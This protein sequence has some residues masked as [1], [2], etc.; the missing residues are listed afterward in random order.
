V[1]STE[2]L[3]FYGIHPR[4]GIEALEAFGIVPRC[5]NWLMHDYLAPYWTY[6]GCLHALCNQHLL[7]ELK[8][9]AEEQEQV[10]AGDLGQYLRHL[11]HR[12]QEQGPLDPSQFRSVLARFRRLVGQ[13][14]QLHPKQVGRGKQSKAANLL[15]RLEEREESYL[16]FLWNPAVPFTN[17]QAEQDIRMMKVRQKISGGFRSLAGGRVF[18]RI[19]SYLSTC[20]KQGHNL[21]EA[22][23]R[24]VQGRP[25]LPV[26]AALS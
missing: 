5:Q 18:A 22:L 7:R 1:A 11:H 6:K 17:N 16:A 3:T 21:W 10:W 9:L 13:G 4:R 8:F 14:R 19:R 25:F 24:A 2:R 26:A 20:R 15:D 23:Q 12:V